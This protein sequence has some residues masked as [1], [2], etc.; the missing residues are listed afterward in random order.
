MGESSMATPL[1]EQYRASDEL[2]ARLRF[3]T[4]SGHIWLD[5]QRMI[6]LHADSMGELRRELID[7]LG[8]ERA[9]GLLT[10]IGY[11][12]GVRD[13]KFARR[14]FPNASDSEVYVVGPQLH[15]LQGIVNVRPERFRMDASRGIC[16]GEFIWEDSY[17]ANVHR[18][19]SG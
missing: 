7:S 16:D 3:E 6:L 1:D 5:E 10:R 15:N 12:S 17:E 11:A 4:E 19:A 14:L 8:R 2:K 18:D 13:A 9:R